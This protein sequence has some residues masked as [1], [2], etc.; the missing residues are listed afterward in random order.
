MDPV[1]SLEDAL[2]YTGATGDPDDAGSQAWI[3]S[4]LLDAMS[5]V[6]RKR[7]RR[8]LEGEPTDY[9]QVIQIRGAYVFNLPFG[10]VDPD[11]GIVITP[12]L[13]DGEELD[14][15]EESQVRLEDA[16]TGRVRITAKHEYVRVEW[17]ATG[18]ISASIRQAV[19]EWL[20][21][22]FDSRDRARDLAS[23]QT[24]DDA[25]SYFASLAGQPPASLAAAIGLAW[26]GQAAVI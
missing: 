25:E 2:A 14:A 6:V 13:F 7:T 26:N 17:T 21:D 1:V 20:K 12:V 5:D 19:F 24:G 15:L 10:P 4:G 11:A 8:A 22:R 18:E 16:E 23:Y 9:D 3:V